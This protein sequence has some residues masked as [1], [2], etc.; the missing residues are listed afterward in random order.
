[1]S[2]SQLTQL[3]PSESEATSQAWPPTACHASSCARRSGGVAA[4]SDAAICDCRSC[5]SCDRVAA[6]CGAGVMSWSQLTQLLPLESD[7]TSQAWPPTTCHASNRARRSGVAAAT[8]DPAIS[9]YRSPEPRPGR[10][11]PKTTC[12][13][14]GT[15][16][17]SCVAPCPRST[18]S[19][20][21][22]PARGWRLRSP[23]RK[24]WFVA[25]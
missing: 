20:R 15:L 8:G 7:A 24:M 19:T 11:L 23:C 10:G 18:R 3:L 16:P 21:W 13:H 22:S 4:T 25:H 2:W 9:D 5:V 1:M 12:V 6:A 14:T 17:V